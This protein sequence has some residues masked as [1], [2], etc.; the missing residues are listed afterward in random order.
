M[1]YF[2]INVVLRT[3][4]HYVLESPRICLW[5]HAHTRKMEKLKSS[6]FTFLLEVRWLMSFDGSFTVH[7]EKIRLDRVPNPRTR[8]FLVSILHILRKRWA[9]TL[10]CPR[11][12][13][14]LHIARCWTN[15]SSTYR[16]F[17]TALPF[18]VIL[19]SSFDLFILTRAVDSLL[20][21]TSVSVAKHHFLVAHLHCPRLPVTVY[22][23]LRDWPSHSSPPVLSTS[24]TNMRW[25]WIPLFRLFLSQN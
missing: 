16:K 21:S 22:A 10:H 15:T 7:S 24:I 4:V 6:D 14:L 23:F 13:I 17:T 3:T 19:S 18:A 8:I 2:S 25:V 5:P 1:Q 12:F 9:Q 11:T 20:I